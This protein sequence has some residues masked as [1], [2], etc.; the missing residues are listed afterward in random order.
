MMLIKSC[1]IQ[2]QNRCAAVANI[3]CRHSIF[4]GIISSIFI[5]LSF[6]FSATILLCVTLYEH[7]TIIHHSDK[8]KKTADLRKIKRAAK[9]THKTDRI[10]I[11][12]GTAHLILPDRTQAHPPPYKQ[13]LYNSKPIYE[14]KPTIKT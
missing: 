13:T 4:P 3:S 7:P 10:P 1:R 8:C 14:P 6:R 2:K 9:P 5:F 12:I 11:A